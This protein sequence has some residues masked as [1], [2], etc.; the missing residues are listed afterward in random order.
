[1]NNNFSF[2]KNQFEVVGNTKLK[3]Y[4]DGSFNI[5]CC[6]KNIFTAQG[7][8]ISSFEDC[9]FSKDLPQNYDTSN[10]SRKDS[11]RRAKAKVHD[12]S[13]L[14]QFNYFVTLTLSTEKI[15]DRY[16]R[17]LVKE[18]LRT[19]LNNMVIRKNL[20]YLLLPE[21]HKDGA[22]HMHMLCSG[23]L[24]LYN[25]GYYDKNKKEI[26]GLKNWKL[27]FSSVYQIY[28]DRSHVSK[29][30]TKYVTKD[31]QKIFGKFYYS[32]G[33]NLKR[34]V[35]FKVLDIDFSAL[36]D[37]KKYYI[38]GTNT[39]FCYPTIDDLIERGLL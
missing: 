8:E 25:T 34:D 1:M 13:L 38:S 33:K 19:W 27:G 35:P 26:I 2:L 3:I 31:S 7:Y 39:S 15:G 29:Y 16:D 28:G 11:I 32:G 24:D 21:Y 37:L 17:Q 4:P 10:P 5:T 22:I 30:I 6:S 18:K 9:K 12:I 36:Y 14:N 20:S 23:D